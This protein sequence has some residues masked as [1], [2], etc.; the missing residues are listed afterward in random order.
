MQIAQK[1][2]AGLHMWHTEPQDAK[3]IRVIIVHGIAEHSGRY[4][5]T[6]QFFDQHGIETVLFD[7]RGHGK[8]SGEKQVIERFEDYVEDVQKIILWCEKNRLAKITFLMG[9]SMGALIVLYRDLLK[10]PGNIKGYLVNAT[11][12]A[13]G[14]GISPFKILFAKAL[15][16]FLPKAKVPN[17]LAKEDLMNDPLE[18]AKY[19]KDALIARYSTV[20]QGTELLRVMDKVL[21]Q[22]G[23]LEK[24]IFV[25]YGDLD[26]VVD[27]TKIAEYFQLLSAKDKKLKVYTGALHELNHDLKADEFHKD[28]LDWI[29]LHSQDDI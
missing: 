7:L 23:L 8:S 16:R 12:L 27:V 19:D 11:P 29:L 3:S 18:L 26:K 14:G 24:P 21:A 17:V 5:K 10:K 4:E 22:A 20:R 28:Y 13:P 9:H 1:K 25:S 2:I 6:A 15:G